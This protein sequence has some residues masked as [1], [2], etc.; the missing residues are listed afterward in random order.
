MTQKKVEQELRESNWKLEN[1]AYVAAH[2]LKS[3]IQTIKS[4]VELI[5]FKVADID[6]CTLTYLDKITK[7]S[8]NAL[9]LI[10]DLLNLSK[11]E[12]FAGDL[13][14][15]R[16]STILDEV[17][18]NLEEKIT[19]SGT[20]IDLDPSLANRYVFCQKNLIVHVFQNL[21]SNSIKFNHKQPIIRIGVLHPL[22]EAD[23][24][25]IYVR[26]NG[27]GIPETTRDKIFDIF[28]RGE[29]E[30]EG[31]GIGLS[32]VKRVIELHDSNIWFESKENDGTTF[33]FALRKGRVTANGQREE[34][35][36]STGQKQGI[37]CPS[38]VGI[39]SIDQQGKEAQEAPEESP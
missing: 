3:P 23:K 20:V 35:G 13:N 11:L 25:V 22:Y 14:S 2:D 27:I 29:S 28:S 1:F 33:F 32:I 8:T 5:K 21:I 38:E 34:G 39:G 4:I 36:I 37:L 10:Q 18:L 30:Y 19:E 15:V 7:V 16:I 6:E 31:S 26:D 17:L 9:S 12:N 24:W